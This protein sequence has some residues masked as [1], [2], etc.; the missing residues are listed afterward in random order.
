MAGNCPYRCLE[1]K[2]HD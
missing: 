2:I 1:R